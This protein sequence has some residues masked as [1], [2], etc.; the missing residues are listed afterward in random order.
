MPAPSA[1]RLT[2]AQ[3]HVL[4]ALAEGPCHGYAIML[5]ARESAGAGVSMGPGT[6]YG[7]LERLEEAGWVAERTA[8]AGRRRTFELLPPGRAALEREA[9]RVARLAELLRARRLLDAG[10]AR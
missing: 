10:Q 6:V 8:E 3:F 4:L 5:A 7:T 1:R 9:A 2:P